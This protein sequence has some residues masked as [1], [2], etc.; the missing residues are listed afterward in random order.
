RHQRRRDADRP[1]ENLGMIGPVA[2]DEL[3]REIAAMRRAESGPES[4]APRSEAVSTDAADDG[5]DPNIDRCRA[6]ARDPY[7]IQAYWNVSP[8]TLARARRELGGGRRI[9]RVHSAPL[10]HR[11]ADSTQPAGFF[12]IEVGD[13]ANNW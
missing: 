5:G 12:D 3:K 9:L 7:W 11:R 2:P 13:E 8:A 1:Y 6:M 4:A 10:E